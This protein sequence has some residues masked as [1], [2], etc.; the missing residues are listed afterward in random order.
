M[1]SASRMR[2]CIRHGDGNGDAGVPEEAIHGLLLLTSWGRSS[3][4]PLPRKMSMPMAS[5]LR[6]VPTVPTVPAM[7]AHTGEVATLTQT[8]GL[9]AAV[10]TLVTVLTLLM[11]PTAWAE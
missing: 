8:Q 6:P 10:S 3:P 11:L 4:P 2:R 9:T 1:H 7:L 5:T